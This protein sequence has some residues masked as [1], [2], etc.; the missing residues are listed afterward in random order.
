MEKENAFWFI[1]GTQHLYGPQV[2]RSAEE[3]ALRVVRDLNEKG[4]RAK[5]RFAFPLQ[6]KA[7]ATTASEAAAL[8]A[9]AQNDPRCLGVV[10]WMHT[11]SPAKMWIQALQALH[12][13]IAHFH[14]QYNAEIPWASIDMDYM[15]L[16]QSAH[17]GREFAHAF[18]RLHKNRKIIVG[19]RDDEEAVRELADWMRAAVGIRESRRVKVLR[20]G[21][22]MRS[23]AV[24]EGDKV[25]AEID[26][27]WSVDGYGVGDLVQR[28]KAA[29]AAEVKKTLDEYLSSYMVQKSLRPGGSEHER[30][31]ESA[32]M[33]T[34]L[35]AFLKETNSTAFTTTFEDLHGL[36]QLPGLLVQRLMADGY[37]FAGEGDWKTAALL[38]CLKVMADGVKTSFME[39]YTYHFGKHTKASG[40]L[41]EDY[42]LGSHMLE[43]CPTIADGKP[44]LECH[45][46][47]IGGKANPVRLVFNGSPGAGLVASLVD[48]GTRFRLIIN[49][50]R[51][52]AI[53]KALPK[54]PVARVLWK[55]DPDLK[56]SAAAW[57]YAGGA[58]HTVYTQTLS[59]Q[60]LVDWADMLGIESLVIGKE[61]TV[62]SVRAQLRTNEAAYRRA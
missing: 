61:S 46:L 7:L 24:T 1:V 29:S 23:V 31:L 36:P 8:C 38:R 48:I 60:Q 59:A 13:P 32:R 47:G 33:E 27:G 34:G 40:L 9:E 21:D 28:I 2:L 15:N 10:F 19:H 18:V 43:V 25:Q 22:N 17:G 4:R 14:T 54:L 58:H 51:S 3:N 35:R 57:M 50:V 62:Q 45:P 26:L 41:K 56:T 16:H 44:L 39:D 49:T 30:L 11:F 42:I 6:Y 55:P 12:K 37:G 52:V 53:P 5:S 20:L